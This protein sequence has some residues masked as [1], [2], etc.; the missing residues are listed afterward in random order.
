MSLQLLFAVVF[1]VAS[2]AIIESAGFEFY[3]LIL[4]FASPILFHLLQTL[5][6]DEESTGVAFGS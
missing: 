5:E 1:T 6:P 2:F 4:F 3:V